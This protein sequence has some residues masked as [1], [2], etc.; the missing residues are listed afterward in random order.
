MGVSIFVPINLQS[1][2]KWLPNI[3]C[4]KGTVYV[5]ACV[6]EH[7]H[8]LRKEEKVL[9]TTIESSCSIQTVNCPKWK[10]LERTYNWI[11][12]NFGFRVLQ[13]S[14]TICSPP[15]KNFLLSWPTRPRSYTKYCRKLREAGKVRSGLPWW[16]THQ[17]VVQC[18]TLSPDS[19]RQTKQDKM[20]LG[21][22]TSVPIHI[23]MQ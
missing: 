9:E 4:Y 2:R 21:I 1:H 11:P 20:C 17:L 23:H 22:N 6:D 5:Y 13:S 7:R 15:H 14:E 12:C 10:F 19:T 3:M 18:Q 16:R 8:V